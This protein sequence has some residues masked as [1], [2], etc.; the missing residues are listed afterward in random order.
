MMRR[1]AWQG[2][3]ST[4][5]AIFLLVI[6]AAL[7]GYMVTFS[8]TQHI[9]SA[10]DLQGSRAYWAARAGIEWAAFQLQ[11]SATACP[12]A[13][14]SFTLE[15]FTVTVACEGNA[16]TE[17]GSTRRVF[18]LTSTAAPAGPTVGSLAYVERSIHAFVEFN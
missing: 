10:A 11:A 14:S 8:N 9:T 6:L 7:G 13:S 17:G 15:G 1:V 16:Y 2:G 4:V 18:R 12:A 5:A 3:F